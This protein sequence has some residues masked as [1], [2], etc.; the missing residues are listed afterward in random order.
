MSSENFSMIFGLSSAAI[1]GAADFCGGCATK[2]NGVCTVIVLSQLFSLT[3]LAVLAPAIEGAIPSPEKM[4]Y[5]GLAGFF[6]AIGLA[7]L[8]RGLAVG[9]MGVVAPLSSVIGAA[10][11]VI[12]GM[13]TEGLP[14]A[15]TMAGMAIALVSIWFLARPRKIDSLRTADLALPVAA[16]LGFGFFFICIKQVSA[17][18]ILWPLVA[19]RIVSIAALTA[20]LV[21]RKEGA[22]PSRNQ[23]GLIVLAGFLDT[24][25]NVLFALATRF[26][27]LDISTI[28][29]SLYPASTIFLAW[30]ILKERLSGGQWAG[31]A[32]AL[33]ALV[34]IA[35]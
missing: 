26:G 15:A 10:L 7:C 23:L 20:V 8:Y 16:G 19:A 27:R 24:A 32:S 17:S 13:A 34:L 4:V 12:V 9:T 30:F 33:I 1:F 21:C 22:P 35:S 11:P 28:L 5:G 2:K 29:T 3:L 14:A 25:G 31:V 6:G 18:S